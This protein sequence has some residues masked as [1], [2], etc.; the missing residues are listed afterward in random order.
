MTIKIITVTILLAASLLLFT[1]CGDK[2]KKENSIT[3]ENHTIDKAGNSASI[4]R[5]VTVVV[6]KLVSLEL[7]VNF[8]V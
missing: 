7:I 1:A 6:P 4:D 5:V 8:R 2:D 3:V